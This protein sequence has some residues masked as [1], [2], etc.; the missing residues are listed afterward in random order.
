MHFIR[1]F[2]LRILLN[3][4]LFG[5]KWYFYYEREKFKTENIVYEQ[6]LTRLLKCV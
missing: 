2:S 4:H 5:K 6:F 3:I 1:L